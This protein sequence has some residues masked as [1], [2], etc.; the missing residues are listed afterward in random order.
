[1]QLTYLPSNDGDSLQSK[2]SDLMN[3]THLKCMRLKP[4][5]LRDENGFSN[6]IFAT[7]L[8]MTLIVF[9]FSKQLTS[10]LLC[11]NHSFGS[12]TTFT[13]WSLLTSQFHII[14]FAFN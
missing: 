8:S 5:K 11:D 14:P 6:T 12:K 10:Y 7:C 4:Q 3:I 1:M 9:Y 13:V 2:F